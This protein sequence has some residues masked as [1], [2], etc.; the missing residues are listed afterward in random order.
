MCHI[1]IL[2]VSIEHKIMFLFLPQANSA[3]FWQ[4]GNAAPT[5][6]KKNLSGNSP[7]SGSASDCPDDFRFNIRLAIRQSKRTMAIVTITVI[8]SA[9]WQHRHFIR[10]AS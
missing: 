7:T 2:D 10:V 4:G 9:Q 5:Q 8:L 3:G 6:R 1:S